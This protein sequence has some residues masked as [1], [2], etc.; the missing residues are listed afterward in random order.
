METKTH[1]R[2]V[3]DPNFLGSWDLMDDNGKFTTRVLTIKEFK[4]QKSV[5]HRGQEVEV[6]VLS[7]NETK[8]MIVNHTN[9]KSIAKALNTPY[10]EDW[11][12][13]QIELKV[14]QVK[15]FGEIH[16]ALRVSKIAPAVKAQ[17]KVMSNEQ[18]AK[19]VDKVNAKEM[20]IEAF[21]QALVKYQ[22]TK[23][24]TALIQTLKNNSNGSESK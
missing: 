2:K 11:L 12:G 23:E 3:K 13:K 15:A 10:I 5:D 24:Q 18:F 4:S 17:P 20:T 21:E 14:V 8:P 22:L 19:G 7:F 9:V 6:A 16:D 1:F